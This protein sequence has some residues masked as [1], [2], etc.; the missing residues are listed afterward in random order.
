MKRHAAG[1]LVAALCA[2]SIA[3][4][5][6]SGGGT[7]DESDLPFTFEYPDGFEVADDVSVSEQL[8]AA[9]DAQRAVAIDEDNAII[10]Q[11][12]TLNTQ[13][14][15]SDL[16]A[17]KREIGGLLSQVNYSGNLEESKVAGLPALTAEGVQVPSVEEGVS[18]L[19]FVFNGDQEYLINCQSTPEHRPEVDDACDQA[20]ETFTLK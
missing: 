9:A 14:D 2:L 19:T 8:G 12:F 17:A 20:L 13:I 6:D 4:C 16:D 15:E 3:A 7:F 11:L 5:G 1:G 18:N 10:L